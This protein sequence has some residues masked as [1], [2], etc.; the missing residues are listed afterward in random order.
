MRFAIR[1]DASVQ[2]GSG[3]VMRCLTLAQALRERGG[4]VSF[5]CRVLPGHLCD[6]IAAAGHDVLRLPEPS[7]AAASSNEGTSHHEAWLVVDWR[8]DA[9][10]TI[11]LLQRS[12]P[13]DYLIVDH[14][15]LDHRWEGA[16]RPHVGGIM[17]ID[18]L[19]DRDH[20]CDLLL[21]Q[22]YYEGF[23]TRYDARVPASC[24]KLLGPR[25]VLLRPEFSEA[26]RRMRKRDGVVRRGLVF[27]GGADP[28]CE[29]EKA[30]RAIRAIRR[31]E[32][33][34]DVIVGASNPNRQRIEAAC[35]EQPNVRFH[36]QVRDIASRMVDADLAIGAGG[37]SVWERIA[38]GLPALT[39][40][41]AEHQQEILEA[42]VQL[43]VAKHLGRAAD[44]SVD[45]LAGALS[46]LISH[47]DQFRELAAGAASISAIDG[48]GAERACQALMRSPLRITLVSQSDSWINEYLPR[49]SELLQSDGH[50]VQTV[51]EVDR[52]PDGDLAFFLGFGQI[53]PGPVLA[54]H[55]HNLVVHESALPEGKGWSPLTWQILEGKN[56]IPI[57]LFEAAEAVDSGD[58]YLTGTMRFNGLELVNELRRTQAM[59]TIELC[60]Q[61]VR[62]Y[63]EILSAARK[64]TGPST[65][66]RRRGPQDSRLDPDQTIRSQ[67]NLLRVVDNDR[68]PAF[69]EIDG[70]RYVLR[71][72]RKPQ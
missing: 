7:A 53:V 24:R 34:W 26:R 60:M 16:L 65:F 55:R 41:I 19:A 44:V 51:H 31:P 9:R 22:N 63:P 64:Q 8:T 43:G 13:V 57:T 54:R 30:L 62:S 45:D 71:I 15:A 25:F 59:A 46:D 67:F 40:A 32:I 3:H 66:Y 2:I 12:A 36:V 27:I 5:I 4:R 6:V 17:V 72:E 28:T 52:I 35:R 29:T 56:E 68:Y 70:E 37:M 48:Y 14:Y 21:D 47:P 18:D 69:F 42:A 10:Q 23:G 49:L 33:T 38:L 1:V 39:V 20:D 11:D 50:T 58:I 61:F